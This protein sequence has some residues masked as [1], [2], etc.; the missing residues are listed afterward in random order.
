MNSLKETG[1]EFF[2]S[3]P[4]GWWGDLFCR[5]KVGH[6]LYFTDGGIEE[7]S[8]F[9]SSGCSARLLHDRFTAFSVRSGRDDASIASVL[10][11]A[12]SMGGIKK[13]VPGADFPFEREEVFFPGDFSLL[14]ELDR[15]VR[16]R[17]SDVRQVSFSCSVSESRD[18]IVTS[19]CVISH[20]LRHCTFG[21]EVVL[22]HRGRMES[23][24]A[25]FSRTV[26][27]EDFFKMLASRE[28]LNRAFSE[29]QNN[30][31][32]VSCPTGA[33]PV[34][35]SG[36]AGGTIIHEACGHGMEADLVFEEKS[37]F[38][39]RLGTPVASSLVTIVDDARTGGLYGSFDFD[40]EG[41]P[42]TETVLVE[43]GILRNY[44]TDRRSARLYD[45]PV[46]GNG[47]RASYSSLPLPRMSNTF[48]RPGS[49]SF[50]EM[51]SGIQGG[52]YVTGMGGG[53]VNTTTGEFVFNVTQGYRINNGRIAEPVKGASLIGR[54]I[55]V[56]TGIR[57]VG[58]NLHME[59]GICE[60]EG[61]GLP[62][63][64]G[65]PSLLIDGLVV[66][67]TASDL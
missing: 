27:P 30:M 10:S 66:G 64:D 57:A 56:L 4:D 43:N 59:P 21:A 28:V 32:A 9:S 67:G 8:S 48:V 51:I 13:A 18:L 29:A 60:K 11:D 39:G 15:E 52:L 2:L 63:T 37:S 31:S 26:R 38:A 41:T 20:P 40:D 36:E 33:M 1:R 42:A 17:C 46:T 61:Q 54:G 47:R 62:V 35:L 7:I 25:A 44:L 34:L 3:L 12:L 6:S 53:E 50:E 14:Y 65:Q 16:S 23:G 22:E 5:S 58:S 45:L 19:G 49:S 55:D 24:Y